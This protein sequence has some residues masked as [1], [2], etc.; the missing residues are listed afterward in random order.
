MLNEIIFILFLCITT[1]VSFECYEPGTQANKTIRGINTCVCKFGYYGF[2][3]SEIN[4]CLAGAE[5]LDIDCLFILSN[6]EEQ[7]NIG[8][9]RC[10][11]LRRSH[12]KQCNCPDGFTGE[13]CE[14]IVK[15]NLE[16]WLQVQ[17]TSLDVFQ[18][19]EEFPSEDKS[20]IELI[21]K[22][23]QL[24][25]IFIFAMIKNI[26]KI[27]IIFLICVAVCVLNR[28]RPKVKFQALTQTQ[29]HIEPPPAYNLITHV[30]NELDENEKTKI[31][32]EEIIIVKQP[33]LHV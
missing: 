21:I 18:K 26:S 31:E 6:F 11:R 3:C 33:R 30:R 14:V 25:A 10:I 2:R 23:S 16:T 17:Q 13:T 24:I 7:Q 5:L 20:N 9:D 28:R 27:L 22:I 19:S 8:L 29:R 1:V 32:V 12:V 4:K 15:D